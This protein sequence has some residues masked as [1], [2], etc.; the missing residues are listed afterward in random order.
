[1]AKSLAPDTVERVAG[2]GALALLSV[3]LTAVWRGMP[4]WGELPITIWV[5]LAAMIVVLV[6]TPLLLWRRRGTRAHR[7][8]GW[9]WAIAMLV[10]AADSVLVKTVN[11]GHFSPIHLLSVLV[12]F[13]VPL[14]VFNARRH[15]VAEHRR[16]MRALTIGALLI[17]GFFTF[18]F[19]RLLGRWLFG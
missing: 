2:L 17:A 7:L 18:P 10:S 14:A 16:T 5:H 13:A 4:H 8:L 6:L 1:M 12:L 11:P 9:I 3:V 15:R 19:G